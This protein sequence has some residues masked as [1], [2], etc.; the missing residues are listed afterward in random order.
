M[1]V[2]RDLLPHHTV[3]DSSEMRFSSPFSSEDLKHLAISSVVIRHVAWFLRF[4][5]FTSW[6]SPF[7]LSP[8]QVK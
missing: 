8:I 1:Y 3:E 6:P 4:Y 7:T 5:V 2:Q